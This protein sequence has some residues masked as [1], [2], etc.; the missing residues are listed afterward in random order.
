M[1]NR[2]E[3]DTSSTEAKAPAVDLVWGAKAIAAEIR[4][5]VR[6]AFYLLS[7]KLIPGRKVGRDW[8]ADRQAL[9][10]YFAPPS[11]VASTE[12]PVAG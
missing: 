1:L 6:K 4:V 9:R 10:D 8:V 2:T 12:A 11:A 5:P 3:V 7:K